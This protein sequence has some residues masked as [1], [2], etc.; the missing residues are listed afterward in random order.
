MDHVRLAERLDRN[1]GLRGRCDPHRT[2]PAPV[3]GRPGPGAGPPGA[4]PAGGT[5]P[6]AA[7]LFAAASPPSSPL[8]SPGADADDA[9]R[10]R[11]VALVPEPD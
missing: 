7:Q 11:A 5:E 2:G 1:T 8:P 9:R 10:L 6:A 3:R 4:G